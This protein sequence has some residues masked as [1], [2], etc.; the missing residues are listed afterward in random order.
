MFEDFR[1]GKLGPYT[2]LEKIAEGGMGAVYRA[3]QDNPRRSVALKVIRPDRSSPELLRRFEH[4]AQILGRLHHPCIAQIFEAGTAEGVHGLQP[5]FAMELVEGEILTDYADRAGLDVKDRLQLMRQIAEG[6][7]HAHQ[8]GVIHRDLKPANVLVGAD[9]SPKILDF[10]VARVTD[11]DLKATLQTDVGQLLGTLPYMSPEQVAAD[12]LALDTRSDVYAMGVMLYELLTGKLP[13]DMEGHMIHEVARIIRE[14]EPRP[15]SSVDH[16]LSGDLDT[17]VGKA[18]EKDKTRRY[19]SASALAEDLTRFLRDEPIIA[20]RPSAAYQLRKFAQRNRA[21]VLGTLGVFLALVIGFVVATLEAMRA[22]A[23]EVVATE[24]AESA[25]LAGLEADAKRAEAETARAAERTAREDAEAAAVHAR[26][27]AEKTSITN[28]FLV[29]MF[30]SVQPENARG[31]EVTVREVLDE[32]AR[33]INRGAL[34]DSAAVEISV[35]QTLGR[36][37]TAIARYDDARVHL[38]RALALARDVEATPLI[39]AMLKS[40]LARLYLLVGKYAKAEE[41][42]LVL[43]AEF[44]SIL[45]PGSEHAVEI[46]GHLALL[47]HHQSRFD[48]GLRLA[49]R[50]NEE[51]SALHPEGSVRLIP[52]L[53]SL[54]FHLHAN[55]KYEDAESTIIQA[56]E[57][58]ETTGNLDDPDRIRL[59]S[60][61]ALIYSTDGRSEY[62]TEALE[63]ALELATSCFDSDHPRVADLCQRLGSIL[64]S[65]RRPDK[66]IELMDR[67]LQIRRARLGPAADTATSL[68]EMAQTLRQMDRLDEAEEFARESLSMRQAVFGGE[69]AAI[70]ASLLKLGAIRAAQG[71]LEDAEQLLRRAVEN[72][73]LYLPEGH[74]DLAEALKEHGV[75]LRRLGSLGDAELALQEALRVVASTFAP[76]HHRQQQMRDHLIQVL[77]DAGRWA[78]AEEL[79]RDTLAVSTRGNRS[80]Q[81][82]LQIS[83]GAALTGQERFEEADALLFDAW[84]V[85]VADTRLLDETMAEAAERI[86]FFFEAAGGPEESEHWR[87]IRDSYRD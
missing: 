58:F 50:F 47:R 85:L 8:K 32:A 14:V 79:V 25:R 21:V 74:A 28:D 33:N 44:D 66:A 13:Y 38:D 9:G 19:E 39:I 76:D 48:E 12:P 72:W 71:E 86:R 4:E 35:R 18:L 57:L 81:A 82:S 34:T 56:L 7:H 68:S 80:L 5:Y 10:G 29:E 37:Y 59:L 11:S 30:E 64:N 53:S 60:R 46:L 54:S 78:A 70:G 55:R 63:E 49:R 31:R 42:L 15:M 65:M 24:Q 16:H 23:A 52:G 3:L 83:L 77:L 45:G 61:L 41:L 69:S 17:L 20:R 22:N 73:R 84:E 67:A 87:E 62:A 1:D 2:I 6:V 27:E 26:E 36:T 51:L 40:E 75:I 43:G